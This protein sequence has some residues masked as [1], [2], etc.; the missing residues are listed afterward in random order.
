MRAAVLTD[1]HQP[2]S[3]EELTPVDPGPHDV[4]VK[5][6]ASGVCHS[7][8]S[9]AS[10][11][12]PAPLPMIQGHEGAGVVEA[13]G[14]QVTRVKPGDSVISAV[15]GACGSCWWCVNGQQNLCVN[16]V[17]VG[18]SKATRSDGAEVLPFGGLGTFSD[19]MI[20]DE[21]RVVKVDTTLPFE[22]LALIGCGVMTG[23]CAA[24]NTAQVKP[25]SSVAVIGCGGVGLSIIQGAW[26]AGAAKVIAIDPV[27]LKRQM[28][29]QLGAT[30]AIDPKSEDVVDRV[31]S[32]TRGIG[33]DYAFEA[34]ATSRTIVQAIE[35]TRNGGATIVVGSLDEVI[36]VPGKAFRQ[37][38]KKL[39]TSVG[40]SGFPDRDYQR[41][42][43]LAEAGRLDLGAMVTRTV[44]LDEVNDAYR[45]MEAGEVIRT[46]IV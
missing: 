30:H 44:K 46:V 29:L 24:L 17:L 26:I 8:V 13:V 39:L 32:L 7:D 14:G 22:Q 40:G 4:V 42:V 41:L 23:T 45:A 19:L 20:A 31:K 9:V 2:L 36:P 33:V 21:T 15:I 5:V 18:P 3:V 6:M 27:P 11:M 37:G 35:C 12:Y 38:E 1:F 16:V 34:I 10:G 25:A 28:A 43:D